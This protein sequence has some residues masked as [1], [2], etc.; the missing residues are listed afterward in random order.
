MAAEAERGRGQSLAEHALFTI[1]PGDLAMRERIG[2]RR[3]DPEPR[4]G[5]GRQAGD[6]LAAHAMARIIARLEKADGNVVPPQ[7]EPEGE[8]GEAAAHDFDG[9]GRA[10]DR[11]SATIRQA[12]R[13]VVVQRTSHVR[14]SSPSRRGS[15]SR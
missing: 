10:H 14:G 15:S 1:K 9:A 3:A 7:C 4:D 5:G 2:E 8:P 13:A 11:R 12:P 6:E